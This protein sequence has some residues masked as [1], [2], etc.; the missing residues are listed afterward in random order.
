M[1]V[2]VFSHSMWWLNRFEGTAAFKAEH[3]SDVVGL[4][5]L[6]AGTGNIP[7]K[8]GARIRFDRFAVCGTLQKS[9]SVAKHWKGSLL[10]SSS[11]WTSA[12]VP[13]AAACGFEADEGLGVPE[14]LGDDVGH[15]ACPH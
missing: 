6:Q 8:S 12:K 3:Y 15:A 1:C 5:L 7:G 14:R 11:K 4:G 13:A 9:A 10:C 2:K